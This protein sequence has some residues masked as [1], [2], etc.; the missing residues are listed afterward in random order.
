MNQAKFKLLI[1]ALAAILAVSSFAQAQTT[2]ASAPTKSAG[3]RGDGSG[4]YPDADPP[5]QWNRVS[6]AIKELSAQARKPADD[7]QPAKEDAI[8]D[9]IIRKWLV[10]G[11][12]KLAED[13][14]PDDTLADAQTLSPD[15]DDKAG[16]LPWREVTLE[17]PCMDLCAIMNVK[18]TE[19][20]FAA[21]AHAY[22]YSPSGQPVA[23]NLMFQGQGMQRAWLN[24]EPLY[25]SGKIELAPGVRL[26]LPLKK[27]WNRL[28]IFN[29]KVTIE[30]KTWWNSGALVADKNP[31]YESSGILW[32]TPLPSAGASAPVIIGDRLFFTCETG[33]VMC[34]N[35]ADGKILWVRSLTY[36]DFAT[37]EERKANPEIFTAL[38]AA[39]AQVKK[40]DETDA[41]MP[42]KAPATEKDWR[43]NAEGQLFKGM[44]KVSKDRYNNPATWG[45]EAGYTP[46]TPL[47]DGK[48]VYALFGTGILACYD[49]DGNLKWKR[50]LK[51]AM[52]EHGY[53][54]SPLMVDGK[55][56]IYFDNFTVLDPKTGD[57]LIERPHLNTTK[58]DAPSW[59]NHFHGS[60]CV[61]QAGNEKVVYYLNGE[62]VRLSD[63]KSLELDRK[64]LNI[65][66]P[67]NYTDGTANRCATPTVADGVAY[68]ITRADGGVASFKLPALQGDKVEPEI[69]Q[70]VPFA[71]DQFPYYYG[72]C[73]CASGLLHEGLLYCLN[74]FGLLTVVDMA[75]GEVA[76]QR[77]LDIDVVMPYNGAG[78]LKGG[79]AASPTLAG[80][81]IY[82]WG[83]QGTCL[84]IEPGRKFK[85]VARN[86]IENFTASWPAH[87]EATTTEPIFE[88]QR[89]YY[90]GEYTLY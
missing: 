24:G 71:T 70:Q 78:N 50:L 79:S 10:A 60:G 25:N 13:K 1:P 84:V 31:Q 58:S 5:L 85:V 35:K 76:Y 77:Q 55:L 90:R 53:T 26:V 65:L 37:E 88:G 82:F 56:V 54:T 51:H 8:A 14:K 4:R 21:Y 89:M 64:I 29:A 47:T 7:A 39:A 34:V 57:V 69:I 81:Y 62:F 87:Q 20:G 66:K 16:D 22:I 75:K 6:T 15:K 27:G 74:D 59:Y 33:S 30:R 42:W 41:V 2:T 19:K 83:N 43:F 67:E 48:H 40:H 32:A 46:C 36:Y 72:S 28:M 73:H 86:R 52:V 38:D 11:P 44:A 63:G 17:T 18:P 3:W 61:L 9:G 68:K 12:F 45:C 23:Y 49:V 80:K